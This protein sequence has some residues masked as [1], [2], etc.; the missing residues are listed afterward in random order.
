MDAEMEVL[1]KLLLSREDAAFELLELCP[2]SQQRVSIAAAAI[3]HSVLINDELHNPTTNRRAW[4][5]LSDAIKVQEFLFE[6]H[7]KNMRYFERQLSQ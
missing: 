2:T 6:M 3:G 5:V 7:I 1:R 4:T